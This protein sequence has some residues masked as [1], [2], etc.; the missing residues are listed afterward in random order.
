MK[1]TIADGMIEFISCGLSDGL[2]PI[3]QLPPLAPYD[4][5]YL[6]QFSFD[7]ILSKSTYLY[8]T[9]YELHS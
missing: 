8:M 3:H 4:C 2:L 7:Y 9:I 1:Q 5:S 6:L